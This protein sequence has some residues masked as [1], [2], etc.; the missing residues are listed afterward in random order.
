VSRR[1]AMPQNKLLLWTVSARQ[2]IERAQDESETDDPRMW[3]A[4]SPRCYN[5]L[6]CR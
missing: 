5:R 1:F 4:E 2:V 3:R 6:I